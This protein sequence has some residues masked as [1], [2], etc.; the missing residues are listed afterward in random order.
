MKKTTLLLTVFLA[1]FMSIG[2]F[3]LSAAVDSP[4]TL[5]SRTDYNASRKAIEAETRITFGRCRTLTGGDRD[6][7]KA[8]SRATERVKVADLQARY[9]GTVAAAEE[10]RMAHAR[11]GFDVAKARCDSQAGNSRSDCIKAARD[12]RAR[13]LA[14]ARQATT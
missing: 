12:D 8:E 3:G 4:R 10:A 11:A 9:Y 5:M 6:V 1:V 13:A 7:C 14:Q 2:A